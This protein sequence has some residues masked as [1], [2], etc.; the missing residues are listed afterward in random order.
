MMMDFLQHGSRDPFLY[1]DYA[2]SYFQ[3]VSSIEPNLS[4]K[5]TDDQLAILKLYSTEVNNAKRVEESELLYILLTKGEVK[6]SEFVKLIYG[7]YGFVPTIETMVSVIS[8]LNFYFINKRN[9]IKELGSK[10]LVEQNGD[11]ISSSGFF[12]QQLKNTT[13]HRYLLDSVYYGIS[14]FDKTFELSK[15]LDG[16]LLHHKYSRKDICRILNWDKNEES[17]MYG[18]SIKYNTCPIFVNYH[19]EDNIAA[20]TKFEDK[21]I[22]SSHFQWFSKPRRNMESKDVSAIKNHNDSLRLS[23]FIKKSNGEGTDFYYMGDVKPIDES[24]EVTTI[25]DDHGNS[26]SVVKVIFK[27]N[28]PVE[29]SLYDY[30]TK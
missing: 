20:S 2:G 15:Y 6:I 16:F 24:F 23:L 14:R 10:D 17:T 3:F 27:L 9:S 12:N 4:G 7:K 29:D 21:F 28:Q 22:N 19:K 13:F 8:N 26:V 25:L 18:Y 11:L 5:L 1:V 30:L